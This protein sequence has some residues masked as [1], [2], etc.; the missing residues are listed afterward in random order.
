MIQ[1]ATRTASSKAGTNSKPKSQA[2]SGSAGLP[3]RAEQARSAAQSAVD[4]PVGA[5]LEASDRVAELVEPFTGRSAARKQL[6]SYRT[7]LRRTVRRS[8]RRGAKA[9]HKVTS[10]ARKRQRRAR[11]IVEDRTSRA[12]GLVDQATEQLAALR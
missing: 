1:V 10:E 11:K 3:S 6:R 7:Q 9:R 8:E 4:L 2:K 12:Q 5:V